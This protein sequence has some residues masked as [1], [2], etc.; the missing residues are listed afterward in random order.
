[1]DTIITFV[2]YGGIVVVVGAF[3]AGLA[4]AVYKSLA[5]W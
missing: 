5:D 1:M 2:I 3:F 4:K